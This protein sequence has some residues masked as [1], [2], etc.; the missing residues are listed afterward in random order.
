LTLAWA[1]RE[2]SEEESITF[3]HTQFGAD[4]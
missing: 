2:T 1:H 3:M 4:G